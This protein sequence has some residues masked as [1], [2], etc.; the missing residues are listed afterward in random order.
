MGHRALPRV[1]RLYRIRNTGPDQL[2]RA[3]AALKQSHRVGIF[4]MLIACLAL[5][6]T[7]FIYMNTASGAVCA[8]SAAPRCWVARGAGVGFS[9]RLSFFVGAFRANAQVSRCCNRQRIRGRRS[10]CLFLSCSVVW[11]LL[12]RSFFVL[13]C[14]SWHVC[15][16]VR[17]GAALGSLVGLGGTLCYENHNAL[18]T[19]WIMLFIAGCGM[20]ACLFVVVRV[21]LCVCVISWGVQS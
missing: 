16:C 5:S 3:A 12:V 10:S 2:A 15:C 11:G 21:C 4:V 1:A 18:A 17:A 20:V 7:G 6:V 13:L 9:S 19:S 8:V 14:F